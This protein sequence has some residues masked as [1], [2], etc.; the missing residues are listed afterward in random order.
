MQSNH[1][2]YHPAQPA[3]W[4]CQ[5][6]ERFYGDCCVPLNAD[7]AQFVPRCPL[8]ANELR[9]LGAANTAEP[10]WQRIPQFFRYGLQR[11][12][13]AFAT[14]LALAAAFMPGSI[15][16]WLALFS[17][18]TKYFHS[19][20][21]AGSEGARE[22]PGLRTAFAVEGLDLFLKQLGVFLLT[23]VLLWG[24][25]TTGSK[26]LYWL[27]DITI[28]LLLPASI[29]RL[30]LDKELEAAL[31]PGELYTLVRAM[32]WRYLILCAFLFILWQSPGWVTYMLA[33]GLPEMI[34]LPVAAFLFSYFGVV[35]CAMMGY[36]V[37]QYQGAL[38]YAVAEEGRQEYLPE[39]EWRRRRA[40]AEVEIL[41]KEGRRE[42]AVELLAAAVRRDPQDLAL[43]ERYHRLLFGLGA[44]ERCLGHLERYLPLATRLSPAL[45]ASAL[46]DARRL[47]ADY[48]PGDAQVC[49]QVAEALL[50]RHKTREALSL[51]INLHQRF[52]DYPYIPRAYLLAARAFAEGLGQL[53]SAQKLVK[54]VRL[55]YPEAQ[56]PADLAGLEQTLTRLAAA[57]G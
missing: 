33:S 19:V 55:R 23:F 9:F 7:D 8:C 11:G 52:P 22:A 1:C 56:W 10:F 32:G 41:F 30:A 37:F 17:V 53:D 31:H 54:F 2:H 35:M 18:T 14:L 15:L 39:A 43:R 3:T 38:G 26:A 20:I 40:L 34:L 6:C 13:L 28:L 12:P 45:A 46:L 21:E 36:A 24:A 48:L 16:L 5:P 57:A 4:H 27:T 49:E 25:A 44:T 29:I 50:A 42:G 47:K 51:L